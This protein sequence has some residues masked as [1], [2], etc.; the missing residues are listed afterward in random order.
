MVSNPLTHSV[1]IVRVA[2]NFPARE[3]LVA[4][5][6]AAVIAWPAYRNRVRI[7]MG[8]IHHKTRVILG[9]RGLL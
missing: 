1:R 8:Q 6:E 5:L 2:E 9:K 7:E 4:L 3:E